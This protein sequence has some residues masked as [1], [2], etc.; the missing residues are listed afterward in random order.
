MIQPNY[1]LRSARERVASPHAAGQPL[2]R[3]ELAELLNAAVFAASGRTV[4]IDDHY[5]GKLERGVIRWPQDVYRAAFRAV[6]RAPTDVDL[7][8]RRP[9]R[10][11]PPA[12]D[13]A[14]PSTSLIAP[15]T[16]SPGEGKST[17]HRPRQLGSRTTQAGNDPADLEL[18]DEWS[19]MLRR[20]L[21]T[22][23]AA[24]LTALA[25][26]ES[27]LSALDADAMARISV[28]RSIV[29]AQRRREGVI[30]AR[31]IAGTV[32]DHLRLL[33]VVAEDSPDVT[34]RRYAAEA[35]SEGYGFLAWLAW[36]MWEIGSAQRY[37]YAAIRMARRSQHP[38]LPAYM[39]GSA[40]L[41]TG[42]NGNPHRA[43][44]LM[45][46]ARTS[47][48]PRPPE[49][50]QAWLYSTS[51]ATY[52]CARQHDDTWRYLDMAYEAAARIQADDRPPWP[53]IM[54]FD[55]R[56][57]AS[58]RLTAAVDL[59]DS[60]MALQAAPLAA[61]A[62]SHSTQHALNLLAQADAH[63]MKGDCEHSAVLAL[64][65]LN[66]TSTKVSQ[67]VIRAAWRTRQSLPLKSRIPSIQHLDEKL[68]T[69]DPL[70]L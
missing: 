26:L 65:A 28:L 29:T 41:F 21:L 47:L 56:K 42:K 67:R 11:Q 20:E 22:R 68:R 16:L 25:H 55:D 27:Y 23:G 62:R 9:R 54:S 37:Y 48:P 51:A 70:D 14:I 13:E 43:L 53:W 35:L 38:T 64:D 44:D 39:L 49:T 50:V 33:H 36:D 17:E 31:K 15:G 10:A 5:I 59:S 24:T 45:E 34:T 30:P 69:L 58:Y 12:T 46:Q 1:Q 32:V 3:R 57:L 18:L 8:F 63:A 40:A 61:E 60:E 66:A 7:G 2:S 6:L 52:A 4:A 19:A